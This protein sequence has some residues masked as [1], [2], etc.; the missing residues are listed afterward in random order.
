MEIEVHGVPVPQGSK[1]I[2]RGNLVD[3]RSK[4]LK[5]WRRAISTAATNAN[6]PIEIG[7]VRV[8]LTFFMPKPKTVVRQHPSVRPDL[9]KLVRACLDALTG[10][11]FTD[12]GQVCD[13]IAYKRY[14]HEGGVGVRIKVEPL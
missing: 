6:E 14:Q 11:A 3:V 5:A 4:E 1:V 13:L 12:D 9:D 7:A 10:I 8:A 2:M